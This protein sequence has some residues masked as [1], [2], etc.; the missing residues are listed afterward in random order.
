[1][2][3]RGTGQ[4][5]RV[6]EAAERLAVKESTLRAWIL[7]RRLSCVHIGRRAVRIPIS[8]IER[9][10]VEGTVPAREGRR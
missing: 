6:S 9:I 10:I 3:H 1:M 4:L 8:E 7:A 2:E 5:L